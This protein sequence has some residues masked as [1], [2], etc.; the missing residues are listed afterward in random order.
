[1]NIISFKLLLNK[2]KM[3]YN[4]SYNNKKI[5]QLI[6]D[7]LGKSYGIID[8]I[9]MR[10][11]GSQR[12][13]I[14]EASLDISSLIN[15]NSNT[16]SCSIELRPKGI[17]IHFKSILDTY[18]FIIPFHKLIIFKGDKNTVTFFCD[19][20]FIKIDENSNSAYKFIK[21]IIRM[22]LNYNSGKNIYLI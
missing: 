19:T 14:K 3:I 4:I 9:K 16:N 2:K 13:K 6:N 17:L 5:K 15:K 12:L 7:S 20:E 11:I 10:G 22:K 1:M 18:G 8:T 21:K